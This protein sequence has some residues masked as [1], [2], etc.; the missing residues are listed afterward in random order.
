MAWVR[1]E[2]APGALR[3]KLDELEDRLGASPEAGSQTRVATAAGRCRCPRQARVSAV[4]CQ[5]VAS[6]SGVAG[7]LRGGRAD[8][9]GREDARVD[10]RPAGMARLTVGARGF[11]ATGAGTSSGD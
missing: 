7:A 6:S 10:P 11:G 5:N 2:R 8:C 3:A 4:N 1:S 9:L